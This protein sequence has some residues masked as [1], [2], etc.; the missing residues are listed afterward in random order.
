MAIGFSFRTT[1]IHT[2]SRETH[3]HRELATIVLSYTN[4]DPHPRIC[5]LC[6]HDI[7]VP[8]S[9]LAAPNATAAANL[10]VSGW[11]STTVLRS[12]AI[13]AFFFFF[14]FFVDGVVLFNG[15]CFGDGEIAMMVVVVGC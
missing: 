14:V 11:L 12:P 15:R 9:F 4:L 5:I 8:F 1:H 7:Y 10:K 3:H 6:Q 13:S 2:T